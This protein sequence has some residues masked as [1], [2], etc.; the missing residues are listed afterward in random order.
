M[1]LLDSVT[2]IGILLMVYQIMIGWTLRSILEQL[3]AQTKLL[4]AEAEE[5]RWE[6]EDRERERQDRATRPRRPGE[7]PQWAWCPDGGW[8]EGQWAWCPDGGWS[9]LPRA[10]ETDGIVAQR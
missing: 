3:E 2:I 7:G 8:S 1:T 9:D 10:M 5:R 6:R 4:E